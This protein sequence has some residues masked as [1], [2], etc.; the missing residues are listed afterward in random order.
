MHTE[1]LTVVMFSLGAFAAQTAAPP[2]TAVE[3]DRDE[4]RALTL[5]EALAA[6]ENSVESLQWEQTSYTP[7]ST[8]QRRPGWT[9]LEE[10]ERFASHTGQLIHHSRFI[11]FSPPEDKISCDNNLYFGD[12]SHRVAVGIDERL[13]MRTDVDDFFAAGCHIWRVMGRSLDYPSL[14]HGRPLAAVLSAARSI[15]YVPPFSDEPWPGVRV[16]GIP[17]GYLGVS[18]RLDPEHGFAPCIIRVFREADGLP[19]ETLA[20]LEF[21]KTDGVWIPRVGIEGTMCL[22]TVENPDAPLPPCM[23]EDFARS[24]NLEGLPDELRVPELQDRLR[25]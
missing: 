14:V 22:A 18:V 1:I 17:L 23:A 4:V 9:K 21:T 11:Q 7:P 19:I 24:E 15:E 13:G 16:S 3:Y 25:R 20:V 10:S 8:A 12:W 2:A 6:Y 5:L